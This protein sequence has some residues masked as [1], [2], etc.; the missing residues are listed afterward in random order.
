MFSKDNLYL[1]PSPESEPAS[2]K[3]EGSGDGDRGL[4]EF[5][6]PLNLNPSPAECSKIY[7]QDWVYSIY[8]L[9]ADIRHLQ[10]SM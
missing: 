5:I 8:Q 1:L 3:Q 2:S 9:N 7:R 10:D 4:D 6:G